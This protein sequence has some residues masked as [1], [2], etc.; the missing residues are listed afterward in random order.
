ME[1]VD[2]PG[3][4]SEVWKYF[5][6]KCDEEKRPVIDGYSFCRECKTKVAARSGNTSNLITHLRNNHPTIYTAYSKQKT[7]T[8]KKQQKHRLTTKIDYRGAC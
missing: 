8:A 5:G 4:K 1:L 2:K 6:L 7:E 3:C